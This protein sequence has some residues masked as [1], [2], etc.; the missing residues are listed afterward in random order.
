MTHLFSTYSFQIG[1]QS[2]QIGQGAA[3]SLFLFPILLIIVCTQ[4]RLVRKATT[5][6]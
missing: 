6:E 3:I 4:L 1:L 2:G 5:Y